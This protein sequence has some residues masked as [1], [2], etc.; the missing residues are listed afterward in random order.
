M[1]WDETGDLPAFLNTCINFSS[2]SPSLVKNSI[3]GGDDVYSL[4]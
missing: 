2:Q 1:G 3:S 4:L